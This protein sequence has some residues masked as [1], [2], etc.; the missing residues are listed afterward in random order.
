MLSVFAGPPLDYA[1]LDNEA[2]PA[3]RWYAFWLTLAVVLAPL[4]IWGVSTWL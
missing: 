3:V 1:E 4:I 2:P